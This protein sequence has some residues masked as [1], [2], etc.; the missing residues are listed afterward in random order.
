MIKNVDKLYDKTLSSVKSLL[1]DMNDDG[2]EHAVY[3]VDCTVYLLLSHMYY[4][5]A[6][7]LVDVFNII[8]KDY[9][10]GETFN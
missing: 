9:Y 8:M 2:I 4:G 1:H 6:W 3:M 7:E 5:K 10:N